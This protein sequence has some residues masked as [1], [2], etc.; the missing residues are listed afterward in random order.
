MDIQ[1]K[2]LEAVTRQTAA[3]FGALSFK[4]EPA[5]LYSQ[6]GYMIGIGGKRLRPALCLLTYSLY[7]QEFEESILSAAAALELFHSFTLI[8]DDIMDRSPLRRGKPSVWKKWG[9]EAAVLS[10]DAMCIESYSRLCSLDPSKLPA[11][12]RLFTR[13]AAEVCEGQQLDLD[14]ESR[15]SVAMPEYLKMIGLKTGVLLACSAQLGALAAGA[16]EADCAALYDYGFH[17][18]LAFQIADDYLDAFGDEKVFGKPIGGD[19]VN[20]KQSWLLV[21]A[22][23][24][25]P[26]ERRARL[27]ELLDSELEDK[28]KIASV[29]ELYVFLGVDAL[30]REAVRAQTAIALSFAA[31]VQGSPQRP[32]LEGALGSLEAFARSLLG[33]KF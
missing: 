12:L 24:T 5:S 11:A 2:R 26:R 4:E 1:D 17:L 18:G 25:A 14:F 15:G 19:I 16:S 32:L 6:L 10:G 23:E 21:K 30:A 33:R 13:T 20:R 3:L 9:L 27:L 28:P 22:L 8:H 31:K 29:K 7:N